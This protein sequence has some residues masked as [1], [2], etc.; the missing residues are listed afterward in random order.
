MKGHRSNSKNFNIYSIFPLE[1][2]QDKW[3]AVFQMSH[4]EMDSEDKV[5]H[6]DRHPCK[7]SGY[8]HPHSIWQIPD[9]PK[10]PNGRCQHYISWLGEEYKGRHGRVQALENLLKQWG[11]KTHSQCSKVDWRQ[12]QL[13]FP[14][15]AYSLKNMHLYL[16]LLHDVVMFGSSA[17]SIAWPSTGLLAFL[18]PFV[19][20]LK[21]SPNW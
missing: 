21:D 2:P 18:K 3:R 7:S 11:F 14:F 19:T 13:P 16:L 17:L 10:S 8:S 4:L 9:V 12:R 1:I 20:A 5:V 15:C 6:L